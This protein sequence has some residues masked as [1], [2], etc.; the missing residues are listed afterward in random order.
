MANL[1]TGLVRVYQTFVD[2]G[3]NTS[4]LPRRL[5]RLRVQQRHGGMSV[6]SLGGD[7]SQFL[8]QLTDAGMQ[9]TDSSTTYGLA[10]GYAPINE[11]PTIAELPQTRAARSHI[12]PIAYGSLYQGVAYNEAETSMFADIARTQFNVDGTGVTVG[13]LSTS[14]NQYTA[15][16]RRLAA[17]YA[18][19]D[20]N[21][22]NPVNVIQDDAA[23]T[24][25]RRPRDAGEH[26]RHRAGSQPA[27][28]HRHS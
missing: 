28:R 6:K 24:H 21:P 3:G 4:Q 5:S 22:N 23:R 19:L 7:F 20:L 17:S 16:G 13:V 1:G 8:S 2:S 14:V 15:G 18:T 9:I 11:L 12:M 25:R 27:V 10:A 26:P